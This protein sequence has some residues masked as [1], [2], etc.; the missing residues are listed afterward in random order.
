LIPPALQT[1]GGSKHGSACTMLKISSA[2]NAAAVPNSDFRG[3]DPNP[4]KK[5]ALPFSAVPRPAL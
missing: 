5:I 3:V 4:A 1:G 2:A